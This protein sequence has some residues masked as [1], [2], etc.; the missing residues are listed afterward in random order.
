MSLRPVLPA[1][2]R[3][4]QAHTPLHD[5]LRIGEQYAI[6]GG[7]RFNILGLNKKTE[8]YKQVLAKIKNSKDTDQI[9][10]R[11]DIDHI[12]SLNNMTAETLLR[13]VLK[14]VYNDKYKRQPRENEL[15]QDKSTTIDLIRQYAVTINRD[16]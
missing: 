15:E 14:K 1:Q 5:V 16:R 13:G 8:A 3:V 2:P 10:L 7:A 6:S 11:S 4:Q 12:A 9:L